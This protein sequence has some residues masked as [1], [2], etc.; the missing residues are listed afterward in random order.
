[1]EEITLTTQ[2]GVQL[3]ADYY[4]GP[5]PNAPAVLLLHMM[6]ATKESWREFATKLNEEGFRVLAIDFRGHGKSVFKNNHSINYRNFTSAE[7]QQKIHDIE[8]AIRFLVANKQPK[9]IFLIGASIGANLALQYMSQH[10]RIKAAVLL[11]P[12]INYHGVETEPAAKK[13]A[14]D[15]R[16]FLAAGGDSDTYSTESAEKLY[17]LIKTEK[18]LKIVDNGGHGTDIFASEPSLMK[19]IIAWLEKIYII[20]ERNQ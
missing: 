8:E 1:M 19:E 12:G 2:D 20:E 14:N 5:T 15:Q 9:A 3:Y 4:K 16:V 6:P 7:H 18:K 17:D 11:S 10:S 13:L